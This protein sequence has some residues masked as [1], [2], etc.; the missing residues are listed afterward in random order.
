MSPP[1]IGTHPALSVSGSHGY[2]LVPQSLISQTVYG[3]S[4][5]DSRSPGAE[6]VRS[7][8]LP[9]S[10][11]AS[12]STTSMVL[13]DV[14]R[15]DRGSPMPEGEAS[16]WWLGCCSG[17]GSVRPETEV[18]FSNVFRSTVS[19]EKA[20]LEMFLWRDVCFQLLWDSPVLENI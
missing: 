5:L 11:N 3:S 10:C 12:I 6:S 7:M 16:A 13:V 15:L 20:F 4:Q 1:F 17:S 2:V 19:V 9:R 18:S 8:I 14:G